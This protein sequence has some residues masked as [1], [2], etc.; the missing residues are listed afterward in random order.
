MSAIEGNPDAHHA[1]FSNQNMNVC[2]SRKRSFRCHQN[3]ENGRPLSAR[4]GRR[5]HLA[6]G[7]L[8]LVWNNQLSRNDDFYK[9][10]RESDI[11]N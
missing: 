8:K 11:C 3:Q 7:V 10:L 1:F 2:F 5:E 4:S 9:L 6:F